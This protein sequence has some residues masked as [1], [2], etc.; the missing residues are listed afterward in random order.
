MIREL[1]RKITSEKVIPRRAELDEREEF[2]TDIME[3]IGAADLFGLYIPEAYGGLGMGSFETLLVVEELSRGCCGVS[4]SY[5]ASA[6]GAYPIL[7]YGS[8][9]QKAKYLPDLASGKKLGAFG[10]T[11]ASAGSD[12]SAMKMTALKDGNEYILNGSKQWITNGGVASTYTVIAMTDKAK[13]SRGASAFIVEEGTC[14]FSIGKKEKKMGIRSSMT[15]E[16]V[17]NDCRVSAENLISK[18]GMGFIIAMKTLDMTRPGIGAQGVGLAQGAMETAVDFASKRVQFDQPIIN[19][20]AVQHIL[21]NMATEIEAARALIYATTRT[22]DAGEKNFSKESAMAKLFATD[23]AM[24]V[25]TDAV[26]VMGGHGYMRDYPVEKMM[27][28]A[29]VLQIYEGTNQ[30]QRNVI[31]SQLIKESMAN[32]RQ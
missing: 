13:G 11:E 29:K 24:R 3:A 21:A 28:D 16:L 6:L 18:E 17:F 14:G 25:A 5:A 22:I 2:P 32:N 26:Q 20:Q 15:T 9:E 23:M 8:E 4:V 10:L 19:I 31:A 7:L 12:A 30:I 27:R 1:A